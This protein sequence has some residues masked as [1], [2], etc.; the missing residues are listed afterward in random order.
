M[1]RLAI[2]HNINFYKPLIPYS[3]MIDLSIA[4]NCIAAM[5]KNGTYRGHKI[6]R[7]ARECTGMVGRYEVG[8][9]VIYH[10][11]P[12]EFIDDPRFLTIE[13]PMTLEEIERQRTKRSLLTT[14][15]CMV[16]VPPRYIEEVRT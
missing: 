2:F 14:A 6:G 5:K 9:I 10:E 8:R 11:N 4:L 13:T 7:V 1:I 15:G 12:R 3:T 16:C